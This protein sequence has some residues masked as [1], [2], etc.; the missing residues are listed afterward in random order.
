MAKRSESASARVAA[1]G[2]RLLRFLRRRRRTLSPLLI[3]AHDYPDPD[4]ISSALALKVLA[5][6]EGIQCR[7]AYGGVIGRTENKAMVSLLRIPIRRLAK[8]DLRRHANVALVD[9]QPAF[10]NN[11]FP[12]GRRATIVVDQHRS[13]VRPDAD[14]SI[15]NVR[16]GATSVVL[17][18][19]LLATVRRPSAQVATALAYGILTD[20]MNFFRSSHPAVIGTYLGLLPHADLTLLA[21]I[22]NPTRSR[23]FFQTLARG[24]RRAMTC[25][26][27]VA[28]NLGDIETP[29][30]VSQTADFF[31]SYERIR[32][33]FCTGRYRGR[34]YMSLRTTR[35][36]AEAGEILRDICEDRADAGGHGGVAGG[37]L[38]VG[39]DAPDRAWRAEETGLFVRLLERLKVPRRNAI[40]F[41]F[42]DREEAG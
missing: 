23:R 34:L 5:E 33:A 18:A 17:G 19:A 41:P 27:L 38:E 10:R 31:L 24:I 22:Q 39:R 28:T 29:D 14:F 12:A 26:P 9:T 21:K 3:L 30:L 1:D 4:A 13:A 40:S 6:A 15:V 42:H 25:G 8:G 35:A 20:T 11:R 37:S 2:R 36:G 32:W 7:I 16:C